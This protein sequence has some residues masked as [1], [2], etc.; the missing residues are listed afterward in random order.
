MGSW[1]RI[2]CKAPEGSLYDDPRVAKKIDEYIS[3]KAASAMVS[4]PPSGVPV[5]NDLGEYEVRV[6]VPSQVG[7]IKFILEKHYGLKVT[8]EIEN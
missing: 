6:F 5:K 8:R 7:F 1:Y 2:Y 4:P 3:S